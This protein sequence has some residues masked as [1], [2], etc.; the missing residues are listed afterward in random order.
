[1]QRDLKQKFGIIEL[2]EL[3]CNYWSIPKCGN[4]SIKYGCL[5][6]SGL[7]IETDEDD[8]YASLHDLGVARY[9]DMTMALENGFF[10]FSV[11][12][13][14]IQRALSMYHDFAYKR[15]GK[16]VGGS[17]EFVLAWEQLIASES[18]FS[19]FVSLLLQFDEADVDMHFRS[20]KPRLSSD[21]GRVIPVVFCLEDMPRWLPMLNSKLKRSVQIPHVNRTG[22]VLTA[23]TKDTVSL[24]KMWKDDFSLWSRHKR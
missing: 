6:A 14:P 19:D 18:T 21:D 23:S 24:R 7:E 8:I 20:Y 13:N 1:M 16:A 4:T 5:R 22:T 15:K 9:I 12:R 3:G 10:N 11:V 2:P 17:G